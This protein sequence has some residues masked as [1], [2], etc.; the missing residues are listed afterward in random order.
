LA[1]LVI[2]VDGRRLEVEEDSTILEAAREHGLAIPALCS[3]PALPPG[4][5]S[6]EEVIYQNGVARR[7]QGGAAELDC[8][9]CLVEVA[10]SPEPVR[11]C[12]TLVAGG[13]EVSTQSPRIQEKRRRALTRILRRHPNI[14]L[15]CDRDP[16]C[17]PFSV[18][19]RS[20]NVPD[21][22]VACPG[23][24]GCEL[25]AVCDLV[26]MRNVGIE[27]EPP[28][29]TP[30][31][32][33]PLIGFD[34]GLCIGCGRCVRVC[35][36]MAGVGALGYVMDE[37]RLKVGTK[38]PTHE[39]SGCRHCLLCVEVCPTGALT[40]KGVRLES[41][42]DEATR[43]EM[44]VPCRAACPL[45]LDIPLFVYLI[46]QKRY[47]DSL[48]VI[49]EKL[50]FPLLCGLICHHPCQPACRRGRLDQEVPIKS[51]KRF[52][53]E[54]AAS[55]PAHTVAES[56]KKV[57]VV[58]AGPAG[59]AAAHWLRA[60]GGHAV[61]MFEQ[62]EEAGGMLWSCIPDFR[63]PREAVAQAAAKV[64]DLGVEIRT[65]QRIASLE[66][67][68]Q[69][70]FDAV[71]LA[72]GTQQELG[73]GLAGEDSPGVMGAL[74]LLRRVKHGPPPQLGARVAV[75]GG[76]NVALD[77]A[78]AALRCGGQEVTV[79]Y[80]RSEREMPASREEFG[81]AQAEGVAF[82][83]QAAPVSIAPGEQ[84][85]RLN[86]VK[87]R[88][89]GKDR[90]GRARV[91]L[92]KGSDYGMVFDSILTAVGQRPRAEDCLGLETDRS[93][94]IKIREGHSHSGLV[95]VFA[96]G[97]VVSGPGNL[98]SAIASGLQAAR[99]V[100]AYLGGASPASDVPGRM[101]LP[102][103]IGESLPAE[104]EGLHPQ[105]AEALRQAGRCLRCS[106]RLGIKCG[107]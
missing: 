58:G 42:P 102:Y 53:S 85:L 49:E 40:E 25:L 101:E 87:T 63:L 34:P 75:I 69:V 72:T 78:R 28:E 13:M 45:D 10:G 96:A 48:A 5:P 95:G 90:S 36:S 61:T 8:G 57:A 97:D 11:A 52:V 22:C 41:P 44:L 37:G 73:L 81:Q 23:Y 14:C 89:S 20:A 68:G 82:H 84:G 80:R 51:L 7:H 83:W 86:L 39:Q 17:P 38:A 65:G 88:L 21:R 104:P 107:A 105:E 70:G 27:R 92:V 43:R 12:A 98:A 31:T 100:G 2:T 56:G 94:R 1:R 24:F 106:L 47:E 26:D 54:N 3:H 71:L 62:A 30:P 6:P 46:S 93:N 18:C 79:V 19:V 9:L 74:E 33:D 29:E 55:R 103:F 77:A 16:R 64:R 4:K 67:L 35:Q 32:D 66:A 15:T 99:E 91:F 50:P 60:R 76:G 59:L